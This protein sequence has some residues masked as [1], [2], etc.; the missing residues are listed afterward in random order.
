MI[1]RG[2]PQEFEKLANDKLAAING[3]YEAIQKERDFH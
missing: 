1:A 2:V 3:A